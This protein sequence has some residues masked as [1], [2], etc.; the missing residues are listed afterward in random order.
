MVAERQARS[1]SAD[2]DTGWPSMT[3]RMRGVLSLEMGVKNLPTKAWLMNAIPD[4]PQSIRAEVMIDFPSMAI[5]IGTTKCLPKGRD[6]STDMDATENAD[7]D[8]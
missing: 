7:K 8:K 4:A 2:E 6:S 5:V 3:S 1:L